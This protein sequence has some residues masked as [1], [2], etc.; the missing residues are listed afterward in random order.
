MEENLKWLWAAFSVAWVMHILYVL[1]L[2]TRQKNLRRQ[3]DDLKAQLEEREGE[4]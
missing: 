2:S 3:I 4:G 1:S